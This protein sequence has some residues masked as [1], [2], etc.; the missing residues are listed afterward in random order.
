[1]HMKSKTVFQ[2]AAA[3]TI[4]AVSFS[5]RSVQAES[6][7]SANAMAIDVAPRPPPEFTWMEFGQSAAWGALTGGA[8]GGL[9]GAVIGAPACATTGYVAGYVAGGV[10]AG[11][12]YLTQHL[13]MTETAMA[14]PARALD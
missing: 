11:A 4:A 13:G 8:A 12:N 7:E 9:G 5:T 3:L 10:T 6:T 1:M 2:L 14:V